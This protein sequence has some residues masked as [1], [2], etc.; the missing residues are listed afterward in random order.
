MPD[1]LCRNCDKGRTTKKKN[2]RKKTLMNYIN[3]KLLLPLLKI[4]SE[5]GDCERMRSH[6]EKILTR[7]GIPCDTDEFGNLTATKG[8]GQG[9]C[10]VAH[11]DTVHDIRGITPV[12]VEHQGTLASFDPR[13]MEQI[14]IGGDDKCGI[15]AALWLLLNTVE[16]GMA[17]FTID[18]EI[19]CVGAS[20]YD[21]ERI[22]HCDF[23]MQADRRGG[24]DLVIEAAGAP[25][26][27]D[28]F[29]LFASDIALD[30]GFLP[31]R[32]GSITDVQDMA[33]SGVGISAVN[34]SAGYIRP[35]TRSEVIYL[36]DLARCVALMANL[37]RTLRGTRWEFKPARS[38]WA[39]PKTVKHPF[40]D[41]DKHPFDDLD[42]HGFGYMDDPLIDEDPQGFLGF[43][44][45][46]PRP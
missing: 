45:W 24:E 12:I 26:C 31:C 23:L 17:V 28:D 18:E 41:L 40:D 36:P 43:P 5:S 4:E 13:T 33:H 8:T 11:L 19:G 32:H 22:Q 10:V 1:L 39:K 29:A 9:P 46:S 25:I 38:R 14:G 15:Y 16:D 6:V 37:W 30:H 42:K 34:I 7:A 20:L 27:S 21:L 44:D 2:H 35:H 3:K